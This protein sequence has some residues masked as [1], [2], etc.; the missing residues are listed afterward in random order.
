MKK[1]LNTSLTV[2]LPKEESTITI[3]KNGWIRDTPYHLIYDSAEFDYTEFL[4][5]VD[6]AQISAYLKKYEIELTEEDINS[7]TFSLSNLVKTLP[8][9]DILG[10]TIRSI[11]RNSIRNEDVYTEN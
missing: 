10:S 3:L 9:D 5:P 1:I 6:Y 7:S 2:K 4:G 8:N 11:N